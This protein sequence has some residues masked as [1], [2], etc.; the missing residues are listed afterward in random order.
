MLRESGGTSEASS[1]LAPFGRKRRAEHGRA[2]RSGPS[3]VKREA[4]CGREAAAIEASY[5]CSLTIGY[6]GWLSGVSE[7]RY[8]PLA[9]CFWRSP[10]IEPRRCKRASRPSSERK[11][12]VVR[13]LRSK[14][15]GSCSGSDL[16]SLLE[17]VSQVLR[18]FSDPLLIRAG[19]WASWA[20]GFAGLAHTR[21]A[22][23]AGPGGRA[24]VLERRQGASDDGVR[25]GQGHT[26]RETR[27]V[28]A[29]GAREA[30]ELDRVRFR[31]ALTSHLE[32]W[33]ELTPPPLDSVR[34]SANSLGRVTDPDSSVMVLRS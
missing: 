15:R 16:E 20:H 32:S 23:D 10:E 13:G 33:R 14:Q 3:V 12:R 29:G 28:G 21:S 4:R 9:R 1:V 18:A 27:V 17:A 25:S 7:C 22:A 24:A 34:T 6:A 26:S 8:E 11:G 31:A 30:P 19:C 5:G 2:C